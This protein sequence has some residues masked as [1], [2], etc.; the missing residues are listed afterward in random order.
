MM[1]DVTEVLQ[2]SHFT[3]LTLYERMDSYWLAHVRGQLTEV[4]PKDQTKVVR[5]GG[6][7]LYPQS[8][9]AGPDGWIPF[10]KYV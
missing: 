9:L 6:K 1:L 5:V 10:K 4:V 2:A 8:H 3:Y 7:Y